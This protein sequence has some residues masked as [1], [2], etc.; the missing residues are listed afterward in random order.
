MS[1]VDVTTLPAARAAR[2]RA[3]GACGPASVRTGTFPC[4][5]GYLRI[6]STREQP[7]NSV[8]YLVGLVVVVIVVLSLLGIT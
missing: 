1:E 2:E 6:E 4:G 7:M 5:S 3:D 8:I